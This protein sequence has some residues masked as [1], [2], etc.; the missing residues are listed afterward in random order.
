MHVCI[1][2]YV[3]KYINASF[4]ILFIL[5]SHYIYYKT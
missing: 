4:L 2:Y 1:M 5:L 3:Y